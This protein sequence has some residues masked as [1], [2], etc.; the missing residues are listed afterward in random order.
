[1]TKKISEL[2]SVQNET[3]SPREIT[4]IQIQDHVRKSP[5]QK[6]NSKNIPTIA[7]DRSR[8]KFK[9]WWK[10]EHIYK[11]PV[12][13]GHGSD[14]YY[15]AK[16]GH[17]FYYTDERT[18]YSKLIKLAEYDYRGKYVAFMIFMSICDDPSWSEHKYDYPVY[19]NSLGK[20]MQFYKH[21]CKETGLITKKDLYNFKFSELERYSYSEDNYE[22][23]K[24]N[25]YYVNL[26]DFKSRYD[27]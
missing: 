12:N 25:D 17:K 4:K 21:K 13:Y 26:M 15:K 7:R 19:L 2:L 18:A 5:V 8:F 10:K 24:V 16:N 9:V 27:I 11:K 1:M 20:E 23:L 3:F 22:Q 6:R 14:I